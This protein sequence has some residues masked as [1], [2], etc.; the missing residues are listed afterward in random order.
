MRLMPRPA[1]P[2]VQAAL[3]APDWRLARRDEFD[4]SV[5]NGV[6]AV[7]GTSGADRTEAFA[8]LGSGELV[9]V[10]TAPGAAGEA[11]AARVVR[12]D[13]TSELRSFSVPVSSGVSGASLAAR[14]VDGFYLALAGPGGVQLQAYGEGA[15]P[16][17]Q[18]DNPLAV[19]TGANAEV[20]VSG[21]LVY[22]RPVRDRRPT[23]RR[24]L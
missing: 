9:T 14:D 13:G 5:S 15:S 3:E 12:I 2:P 20:I 11:R 7:F 22:L 6:I 21:S 19:G 24:R 10:L 8:S 16:L 17:W 23:E 1:L 4:P 18:R